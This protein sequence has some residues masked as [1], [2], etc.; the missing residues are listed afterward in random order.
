VAVHVNDTL[1]GFSGPFQ[2]DFVDAK[3]QVVA[4]TI[5]TVQGRRI[6]V[7]PAH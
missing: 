6:Q 3:G 5:G 2:T 1:D 7:E 4:S